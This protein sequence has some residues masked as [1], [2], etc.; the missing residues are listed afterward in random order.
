MHA[1]YRVSHC[2]TFTLCRMQTW[3][4]FSRSTKE[5]TTQIASLINRAFV[6]LTKVKVTMRRPMDQNR[7]CSRLT[8]P[9]IIPWILIIQLSCNLGQKVVDIQISGSLKW[10][11]MLIASVSSEETR[12]SEILLQV[13]DSSAMQWIPL[14]IEDHTHPWRTMLKSLLRVL[15]IVRSTLM[16]STLRL[17]LTIMTT[18]SRSLTMKTIKWS[19]IT[20]GFQYLIL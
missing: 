5:E 14:S 4:V 3:I 6:N 2:H 10:F 13:Q 20:E 1:I 8:W 9:S 12:D 17:L 19:V 16:C 7:I 11:T 15:H 18:H